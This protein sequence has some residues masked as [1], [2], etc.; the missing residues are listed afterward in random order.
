MVELITHC[1]LLLR[2]AMVEVTEQVWQS[3]SRL[4]QRDYFLSFDHKTGL[5]HVQAGVLLSEIIEHYSAWLVFESYA[6]TS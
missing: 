4:K 2:L 6:G 5:L 1:D 3:R